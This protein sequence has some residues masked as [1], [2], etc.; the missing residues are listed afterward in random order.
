MNDRGA[1]ERRVVSSASGS[2]REGDGLVVMLIHSWKRRYEAPRKA[3]YVLRTSL[4]N[5]THLEPRTVPVCSGTYV[6]GHCLCVQEP[7]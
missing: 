7:A 4:R 5:T 2:F 6:S 1:G 3:S